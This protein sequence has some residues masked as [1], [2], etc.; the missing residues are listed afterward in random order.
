MIDWQTGQ[1]VS[2][3]RLIP[4]WIIF[5]FDRLERQHGL[6]QY[7]AAR[8][9][10][11]EWV[12]QNPLK[13]YQWDGQFEDVQL[14]PPY[15]NLSREQACDVAVLLL[16]EPSPPPTSVAQAEDLLRFAEDQFV[17]W[18]PVKD[19]DGF[20]AT[21]KRGKG[22]HAFITPCVLEQY[23]CYSP[24]A[25]SSAVQ[26][27]AYLKAYEVTRNPSH[28]AKSRALANGL[29]AGQAWAAKSRDAGGEIPTWIM[30][31]RYLNWLNNSFY[32]AE[33]VRSVGAAVEGAGATTNTGA[34]AK[35][36]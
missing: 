24:V 11:W 35:A 31:D 30:T 14:R 7:E 9:R 5:F 21:V 10:A 4:T 26:I 12:L 1:A 8:R 17:F 27:N 29:F 6:K 13:T 22:A 15:A 32:A 33:A 2:P 36:F 16:S 20:I 34:R 18:S 25:R 28:L 3:Q 23:H 19:P